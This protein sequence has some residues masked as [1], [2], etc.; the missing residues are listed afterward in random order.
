MGLAL[1]GRNGRNRLIR[2]GR[3]TGGI[4]RDEF[5]EIFRRASRGKRP[6]EGN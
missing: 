1:L 6:F 5:G 3:V 4:D 2:D